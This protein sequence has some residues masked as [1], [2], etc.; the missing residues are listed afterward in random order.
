V[1]KV[2]HLAVVG[3]L[4]EFYELSCHPKDQVDSSPMGLDLFLGLESSELLLESCPAGV[5]S[6][7]TIYMIS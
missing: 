3:R 6:I 2:V 5:L 1:T 7:S 4:Y